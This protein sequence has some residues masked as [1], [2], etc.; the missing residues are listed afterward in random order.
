M[1]HEREAQVLMVACPLCHSNL[2]FLQNT[3]LRARGHS[4]RIPVLYLTEV[5]G[6]ALGVDPDRLGLKRHFVPVPVDEMIPT[7][8]ASRV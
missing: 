6:L 3:I 8:E 7:E 1:A 4:F 5:V 2:D